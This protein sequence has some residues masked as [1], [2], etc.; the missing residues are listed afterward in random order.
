MN[1][2]VLRA[3]S[4]IGC[5]FRPQG[6]DP[7]IGLDCIGLVVAAFAIPAHSIPRDYALRGGSFDRLKSVLGRFFRGVT[8]T[9]S[10]DVLVFKSGPEQLHL[11]ILTERGFIHAD[12]RLRRVV[13]TPGAAPWPVLSAHRRKVR[14]A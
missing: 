7:E 12:A 3:R 10:G 14:R 8:R 9:A 11:G 2:V 13:E 1:D 4:L 5:R 6:R